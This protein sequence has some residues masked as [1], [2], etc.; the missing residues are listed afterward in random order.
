M[1]LK[2]SVQNALLENTVIQRAHYHKIVLKEKCQWEE[3]PLACLAQ[4]IINAQCKILCLCAPSTTIPLKA[5]QS[6][7]LAQQGVLANFQMRLHQFNAQL[8]FTRIHLTGTASLAHQVIIAWLALLS[9]FP[10]LKEHIRVPSQLKV[11]GHVL[12]VISL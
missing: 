3:P 1:L 12:M 6:V 11:A 4:L 5:M 8:G 2:L 9:L 10:A 7:P